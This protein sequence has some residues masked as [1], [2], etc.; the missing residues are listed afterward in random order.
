MDGALHDKL[1][2]LLDQDRTMKVGTLRP[3][4]WPQTMM[5]GYAN[6]GLA[7]YCFGGP[8]IGDDEPVVSEITGLSMA[9]SVRRVTDAVEAGKALGLLSGRD[10]ALFKQ[11][12]VAIFR[13][14]PMVVTA[15]G[16]D[17]GRADL[18]GAS[19]AA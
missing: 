14:T 7:V 2:S 1:V 5:V 3:D 18:T 11:T 16:H 8:A 19:E 15:P 9:A 6:D 12:D 13:L 10:P 4:G 17:L